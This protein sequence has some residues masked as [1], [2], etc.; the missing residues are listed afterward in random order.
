MSIK[1]R[2]PF[3]ATMATIEQ[4]L[5]DKGPL[6]RLGTVTDKGLGEV[7]AKLGKVAESNTQTA[8]ETQLKQLVTAQEGTTAVLRQIAANTDPAASAGLSLGVALLLLLVDRSGTWDDRYDAGKMLAEKFGER[9]D[10]LDGGRGGKGRNKF[11]REAPGALS[12]S[13]RNADDLFSRITRRDAEQFCEMVPLLLDA[14]EQAGDGSR[15]PAS[16]ANNPSIASRSDV[17]TPEQPV[18]LPAPPP[19]EPKR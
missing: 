5:L 2:N 6:D 10:A 15:D 18:S 11:V 9:L 19:K 1:A 14:F 7:S 17:E 16:P 12:T 4:E 3:Y 8:L 13:G